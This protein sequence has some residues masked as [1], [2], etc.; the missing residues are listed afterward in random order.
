[1][2][3]PPIRFSSTRTTTT[4]NAKRSKSVAQRARAALALNFCLAA[5]A[6]YSGHS[7][8]QTPLPIIDVRSNSRIWLQTGNPNDAYWADDNRWGAGGL[9]EGLLSTQFEQYTGVSPTVGPNGEVAFRTKWRWP[10]GTT[11][12]KGYPALW[13]CP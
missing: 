3:Y 1:M 8:A 5:T 7:A 11:E 12:V 10:K 4:T 6:L 9:A 13:P 2:T